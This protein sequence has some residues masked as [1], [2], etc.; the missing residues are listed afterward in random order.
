MITHGA[1][2][3]EALDRMRRALEAVVIEGVKTTVPFHRWVL[4][5]KD[6]QRGTYST[7]FVENTYDRR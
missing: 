5:N 7:S 3:D 2:R 1:D 6:F 4:A